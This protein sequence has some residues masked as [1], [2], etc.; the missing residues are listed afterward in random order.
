M[1]GFA[2][3]N[4]N[5]SKS[6]KDSNKSKK[7][8]KVIT[9]PT[10][11]D[12][13]RAEAVLSNFIFCQSVPAPPGAESKCTTALA[14]SSKEVSKAEALMEKENINWESISSYNSLTSRILNRSLKN[15][16]KSYDNSTTSTSTTRADHKEEF[17]ELY[18][19]M[20]R[21]NKDELKYVFSLDK[22]Q[23]AIFSDFFR[24]IIK[25]VESVM[26]KAGKCQGKCR[27][28][29]LPGRSE[30]GIY[31]EKGAIKELVE[32]HEW[33][34]NPIVF[35]YGEYLENSISRGLIEK[36][37]EYS[38]GQ[39][40]KEPPSIIYLGKDPM[41]LPMELISTGLSLSCKDNLLNKKEDE[42]I[43]EI[44]FLK[45]NPNQILSSWS[46]IPIHVEVSIL[47]EEEK[48]KFI[49][50]II[51]LRLALGEDLPIGAAS[52]AGEDFSGLGESVKFK[53]WS[54]G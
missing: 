26:I 21:L 5:F 29:I 40:K 50:T 4:P 49:R 27:G 12:M 45:E 6:K 39:K 17:L 54:Y 20:G 23:L 44:N 14:I 48:L 9:F 31:L 3:K 11:H 25:P 41:N 38:I 10:T 53:I 18:K 36:L 43:R 32:K 35:F 28:C 16:S 33:D 46:L 34:K 22:E 7:D 52:A 1:T 19:K 47:S 8:E 13:L 42:I 24:D 37:N 2:G 51:A 15:K 30:K